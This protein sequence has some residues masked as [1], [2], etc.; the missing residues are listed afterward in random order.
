[1]FCASRYVV[2]RTVS[3]QNEDMATKYRGQAPVKLK[4]ET[5]IKSVFA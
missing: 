4:K 5:L 2:Y 1:M 3:F